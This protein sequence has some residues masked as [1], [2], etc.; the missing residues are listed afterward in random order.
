MGDEGAGPY[1][2]KGLENCAFV[3]IRHI[4]AGFL[5]GK[6]GEGEENT[7]ELLIDFYAARGYIASH[8]DIWGAFATIVVFCLL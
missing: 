3:P 8:S 1:L 5:N 7:F 2:Q 4:A 6:R